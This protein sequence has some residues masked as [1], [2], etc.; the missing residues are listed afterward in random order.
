MILVCSLR[1]TLRPGIS[2]FSPVLVVLLA[3]SLLFSLFRLV[4]RRLKRIFREVVQLV[5]HVAL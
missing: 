4:E 2:D 1:L 3:S 5:D